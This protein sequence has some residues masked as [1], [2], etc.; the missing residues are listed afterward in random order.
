MPINRLSESSNSTVIRK[1]VEIEWTLRL[2]CSEGRKSSLGVQ[3][4][5]LGAD[6]PRKDKC[7]GY[8]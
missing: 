2:R 4:T 7:A 5:K 8:R 3:G 1:S 6:I